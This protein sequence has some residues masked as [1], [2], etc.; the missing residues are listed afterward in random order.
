MKRIAKLEVIRHRTLYLWKTGCWKISKRFATF[1]LNSAWFLNISR[2]QLL[3]NC[4]KFTNSYQTFEF[5]LEGF[6]ES[7]VQITRLW[8]KWDNFVENCRPFRRKFVGI[9]SNDFRLQLSLILIGFR[10]GPRAF[11]SGASSSTGRATSACQ[12]EISDLEMLVP[13]LIY[14][15]LLSGSGE[16]TYVIRISNFG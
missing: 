4:V 11:R 6:Y 2:K 7:N 10:T 5:E 3:Q 16:A 14:F 15:D 8:R 12:L 1:Q 9:C 13:H